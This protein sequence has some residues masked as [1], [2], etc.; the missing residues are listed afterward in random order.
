MN[1]FSKIALGT[2]IMTTSC[3]AMA[4]LGGGT[5]GR[6]MDI[7]ANQGNSAEAFYRSY[8]DVTETGVR[9][10]HRYSNDVLVYG[11]FVKTE[12]D[13]GAGASIEGDGYGAGVFYFLP[14]RLEGY[15]V[16]ARASYHTQDGSSSR[17]TLFVNGDTYGNATASEE[18]TGLTAELLVSPVEPIQPNG[19]TWYAG[20]GVSKSD[21]ER[22]LKTGNSPIISDGLTGET[23]DTQV[24]GSLGLVLPTSFGQA[25]AGVDYEDGSTFAVGARY[26]F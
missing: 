3:A 25:F 8:T 2:L 16:A 19:L 4:E 7:E 21:T 17:T 11:D 6:T 20:I 13:L 26:Q 9:V 24:I 12:T 1:T 23:S 14:E 22:S 18:R 10:S 15:D 5:A